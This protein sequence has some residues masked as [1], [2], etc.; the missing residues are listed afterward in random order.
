[1]T[2]LNTA[3][4][5]DDSASDMTENL[6]AVCYG[7]DDA[8]KMACTEATGN[9]SNL[10]EHDFVINVSK[11][12]LDN[13]NSMRECVWEMCY[14]STRECVWETCTVPLIPV[15]SNA[16]KRK[17]QD[18]K[19]QNR[20]QQMEHSMKSQNH[21]KQNNGVKVRKKRR[22]KNTRSK[23][24]NC[25]AGTLNLHHSYDLCV[26]VEKSTLPAHDAKTPSVIPTVM[27]STSECG[28]NVAEDATESSSRFEHS[29]FAQEV[30]VNVSNDMDVESVLQT[31]PL[32]TS[33]CREDL[34]GLS[35][36]TENSDENK[37]VLSDSVVLEKE[38]RE[39]MELLKS[40][41]SVNNCRDC[42]RLAP[43]NSCHTDQ[44]GMHNGVEPSIADWVPDSVEDNISADKQLNKVVLKKNK[45]RKSQRIQM[46]MSTNLEQQNEQ[47]VCTEYKLWKFAFLDSLSAV[48]E[49][50]G[51]AENAIV[52]GIDRTS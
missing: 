28:E 30:R 42:C 21:V 15:N 24:E 22:V 45:R 48:E 25:S 39:K 31:A 29:D 38:C 14:T 5:T 50:A 51:S 12:G 23:S 49:C 41:T 11:P 27:Y 13:D 43:S 17:L 40:D 18:D 37:N 7:A 52:Q 8:E 20:E 33:V 3:F 9:C 1:M 36:K 46:R 4:I 47:R 26:P 35:D 6:D 10:N 32:P 16:S 19:S 34:V 2:D 44:C